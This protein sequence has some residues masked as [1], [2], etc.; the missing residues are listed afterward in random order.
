MLP[1]TQRGSVSC[2]TRSELVAALRRTF[3]VPTSRLSSITLLTSSE[4]AAYLQVPDWAN[5]L[6]Q[7]EHIATVR[8]TQGAQASVYLAED[9][10]TGQVC[11]VKMT[12]IEDF[13]RVRLAVKE[14]EVLKGLDHPN[15]IKPRGF[16]ID[17]DYNRATL[18]LPYL[19]RQT[20]ESIGDLE[21]HQVRRIA[22]QLFDALMYLHSQ[23]LVHR[24]IKPAN[25]M[26]SEDGT[27][28]II[29]FQTATRTLASQWMMTYAGT[30]DFTAPEVRTQNIYSVKVDVWSAATVLLRLCGHKSLDTLPCTDRDCEEW[31]RGTLETDPE[32]RM[33]AEEALHHNWLR[34]VSDS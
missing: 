33:T 24:D 1:K 11:V 13:E 6:V 21:T 23:N 32:K 34:P 20:L 3:T 26:L 22:V 31:F 8:L 10:S 25:L 19:G 7:K 4:Y 16:R 12:D 17:Q 27:L 9:S 18:L 15:I 5:H 14:Y 28:T 29:D 2:T 30:K